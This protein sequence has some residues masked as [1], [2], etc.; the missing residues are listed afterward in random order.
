VGESY[1]PDDVINPGMG[2]HTYFRLRTLKTGKT[3]VKAFLK[4]AGGWGC[5]SLEKRV[6]KVEIE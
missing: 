3:E 1:I 2:G 6:F 4:H 5:T